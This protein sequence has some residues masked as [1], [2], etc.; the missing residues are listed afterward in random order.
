MHLTWGQL[1]HLQVRREGSIDRDTF[2]ALHFLTNTTMA[3][4]VD[5]VTTRTPDKLAFSDKS[6]VQMP[7]LFEEALMLQKRADG[8]L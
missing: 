8:L 4:T 6:G 3:S 5:S 2:V 7:V 1:N